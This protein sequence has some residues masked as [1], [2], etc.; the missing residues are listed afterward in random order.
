MGIFEADQLQTMIETSYRWPMWAAD[1]VGGLTLGTYPQTGMYG[2]SARSLAL[3]IALREGD[4]KQL[5]ILTNWPADREYRHDPLPERIAHAYS[6]LLFGSE[7]TIE[8][9]A[10][11]DQQNMDDMCAENALTFELRRWVDWSVSEGEVWWRVYVDQ[12]VSPWPIL[13]AAS[14]IDVVPLFR[15]R[16]VVACAF[17]SP[18]FEQMLR[19]E[20][21]VIVEIW[22]HIEIQ[23]DGMSRNLLYKGT[24]GEIGRPMPLGSDPDGLTTDLPEEWVHG[25]DV[26]LAGRIPN[27]LGRDWRL[28]ISEYMGVHDLLLDLNEARTIMAENARLVLKARMVVPANSIDESGKFDSGREIIIAETLDDSLDARKTGP[29]AV[30]EYTFH[31]EQLIEHK[32]ELVVDILARCGLAEQ[33]VASKGAATG[34]YTGTALRTRLIPTTMA[35]QGKGKIW[36]D[37]IPKILSAMAQVSELPKEKGG[38]GISW[39]D[40]KTPPAFKRAKPLPDDENEIV[41]RHVMAVQGE[42]ESI[43]QAI[44]VMHPDWTQSQ[45]DDEV[46]KIREDRSGPNPV[47]V[48]PLT[49]PPPVPGTDQP[50]TKDALGAQQPG[51]VGKGAAVTGQSPAARPAVVNAG[52]NK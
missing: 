12:D 36:D 45:I 16:K 21:Q 10:K 27:K 9:S 7:P 1:K 15:G 24:L 29:Y 49:E 19:I 22:R 2:D 5:R 3:W 26:M 41:Q 30:L 40:S 8:A 46:E 38:C 51:V 28:G 37:A 34:A 11:S 47:D 32:N 33:F 23:T 43:E 25:L 14:R 42:I 44:L 20:N 6:D 50:T 48:I 4:R 35:A 13:D 31:A 52:G 39:K 18:I 17:V